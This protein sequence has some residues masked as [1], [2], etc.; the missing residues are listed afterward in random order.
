M[1]T[2]GSFYVGKHPSSRVY[3]YNILAAGILNANSVSA[4]F[5]Q[6]IGI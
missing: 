4:Q 6:D 1:T 2:F 5:P 3:Q